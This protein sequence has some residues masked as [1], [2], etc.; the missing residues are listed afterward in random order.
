MKELAKREEVMERLGSFG[1]LS[2]PCVYFWE[3]CGVMVSDQ[4]KNEGANT[5]LS[6][7]SNKGSIEAVS[8]YGKLLFNSLIASFGNIS[9]FEIFYYDSPFTRKSMEFLKALF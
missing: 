6:Q 3:H 2:V 1:E 9:A 5:F 8:Y 7:I 4:Y